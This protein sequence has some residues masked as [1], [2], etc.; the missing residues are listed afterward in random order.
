MS[1]NGQGELAFFNAKRLDRRNRADHIESATP[2]HD[3]QVMGS[4]R[5][6]DPVRLAILASKSEDYT[7]PFLAPC[8]VLLKRNSNPRALQNKALTDPAV[9]STVPKTVY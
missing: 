8:M 1:A 4:Y 2:C 7:T 5:V 3:G 6:S 9:S